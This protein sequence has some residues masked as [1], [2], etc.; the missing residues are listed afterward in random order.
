VIDTSV[1]IEGII[2]LINM[3]TMSLLYHILEE[4]MGSRWVEC[5]RRTLKLVELSEEPPLEVSGTGTSH[6][7][8]RSR[9]IA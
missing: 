1:K 5:G 4:G 9:R 2:N 3:S 6:D 8:Q 7:N